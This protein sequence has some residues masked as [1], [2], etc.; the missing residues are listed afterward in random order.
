MIDGLR[1]RFEDR[2]HGGFFFTAADQEALIHRTKSFG[3]ESVPAG[4]GVAAAVLGRLGLLLGDLGYLQ[5]AERTLQAGWAPM[6]E[7]PLG[8]MSLLTALEEFL[9]S[10]QIRDHPRTGRRV[11]AL[12]AQHPGHLRTAQRLVFAIPADAVDLPPALAS[13]RLGPRTKPSLMSARA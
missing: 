3:D 2:E 5:A 12:G 4:N 10:P 8:H 9:T 1:A 13:K 11:H 6:A 7:F